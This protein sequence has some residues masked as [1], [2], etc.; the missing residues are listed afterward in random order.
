VTSC[1]D[2]T[3]V[4]TG[5]IIVDYDETADFSQFATFS[6]VTSDVAPPGTPEPSADEVFFN[7]LVNDLIIEAMTGEP[8]CMEYIPTD[9]V[10]DEKQPDLWTANGLARTEGEG[11]YWRCVGGWFWGWWGWQWDSCAWL[12][13][14]PVTVDV[15][16]L[17]LPVGPTPGAGEDPAL[18]FAGLAQSIAGT[19]PDLETKVRAAVQAVFEQWPEKRSC[20][21]TQ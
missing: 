8:G 4:Q 17:F 3:V 9:E 1:A 11:T 20:P 21:A 2:D 18:L 10:S 12:T 13:P 19:G 15:G 6:V 7:E 14:V 16:N 5:Q